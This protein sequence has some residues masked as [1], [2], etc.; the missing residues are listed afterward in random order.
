MCAITVYVNDRLHHHYGRPPKRNPALQAFIAVYLLRERA[1]GID[2]IVKAAVATGTTR[3]A[4]HAALIVLQNGD[5]DLVAS[6][7]KGWEPL[8]RAADKIRARVKLIEAFNNASSDDRAELGRVVG[9]SELF[10][11]VVAPAL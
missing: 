11:S 3:A 8:W 7:L 4:V 1:L 2:T 9:A 5:E 6:V 10:D